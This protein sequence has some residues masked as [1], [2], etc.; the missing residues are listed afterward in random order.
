MSSFSRFADALL[1]TIA[2]VSLVTS[3]IAMASSLWKTIRFVGLCRLFKRCC[4]AMNARLG[5]VNP[6]GV[7]TDRERRMIEGRTSATDRAGPPIIF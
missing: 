4:A 6:M 5:I 3:A 1:P 2:D 7:L